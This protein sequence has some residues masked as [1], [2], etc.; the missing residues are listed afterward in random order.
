M[1]YIVGEVVKKMTSYLKLSIDG[2]GEVHTSELII[3][4]GAEETSVD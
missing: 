3:C 2:I 4:I 1:S